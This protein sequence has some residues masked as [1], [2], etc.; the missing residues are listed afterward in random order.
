MVQTPGYG[1]V[2]FHY[3][4]ID[5]IQAVWKTDGVSYFWLFKIHQGPLKISSVAEVMKESKQPTSKSQTGKPEVTA[6]TEEKGGKF[7]ECCV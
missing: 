7:I 5:E 2:L 3:T 6:P 4:G 1:K